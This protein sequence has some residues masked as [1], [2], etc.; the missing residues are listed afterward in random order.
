MSV[1][2]LLSRTEIE[3]FLQNINLAFDEWTIEELPGYDDVLSK[4]ENVVTP[5]MFGAVGDGDADDTQA[6]E[7]AISTGKILQLAENARY[8]ISS[9]LDI[10]GTDIIGSNAT[11]APDT[12]FTA[13][14]C[15]TGSPVAS[16][17]LDGALDANEHIIPVIDST[18]IEPGQIIELLSDK[19]WYDRNTADWKKGEVHLV[20][21][22]DGD[23]IEIES[24][25]NDVYE[26]SENVI[27]RAYNPSHTSIRDLKIWYPENSQFGDSA[28][29]IYGGKDIRIKNLSI[30]NSSHR[31]LRLQRCYRAEVYG[32]VI[33]GINRSGWGY[34]VHTTG[35]AH[36]DIHNVHF[37]NCRTAVDFSGNQ[38]QGDNG[39]PPSR[40]CRMIECH[41]D[42]R[43]LESQGGSLSSRGAAT[44]PSAEYCDFIGNF[45]EHHSIGVHVRS[46]DCRIINNQFRGISSRY[47]R[48][49]YGSDVVIS[50]NKGVDTQYGFKDDYVSGSPVIPEFAVE[51]QTIFSNRNRTSQISGNTFQCE[52]FLHMTSN[53]R[54]LNVQGNQVILGHDG[55]SGDVRFLDCREAD[56]IEISESIIKNNH[57]IEKGGDLELVRSGITLSGSVKNDISIFSVSEIKIGRQTTYTAFQISNM[58]NGER[59][60]FSFSGWDSS[61]DML[62]VEVEYALWSSSSTNTDRNCAGKEVFFRRGQGSEVI[63]KYQTGIDVSL[64]VDGGNFFVNLDNNGGG[65]I[66][67]HSIIIRINTRNSIQFNGFEQ[68]PQP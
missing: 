49:P 10:A 28:V 43:G 8:K 38:G 11:I 32:G 5:E 62:V 18:G 23:N 26:S 55:F 22:V 59:L 45:F 17:T 64:G 60:R 50:G 34:G 4:L 2:D 68:I 41:S 30:A 36:I 7:G 47:V 63:Y 13:L 66:N 40:Y 54:N 3:Q 42:G 15:L 61:T 46:R 16:T 14:E 25:T 35:S 9:T 52:K 53:I 6:I 44:H 33:E 58:Q 20:K 24:A 12:G 56:V 29:N 19:I 67:R 48:F 65:N 31:G 21:N 39:T 37:R 27:V 51:F 57:I 1:Q